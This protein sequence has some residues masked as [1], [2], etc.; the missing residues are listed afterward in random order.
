MLKKSFHWDSHIAHDDELLKLVDAHS[1]QILAVLAGHLHLTAARQRN[2]VYHVVV[3]GTA[4]YPCDFA[5]Y[6]VFE[7]HIGVRMYSLPEQLLTPDTDNHGKACF[8]HTIDYTDDA[9]PTHESYLKGNPS[10]RA[11][12]IRLKQKN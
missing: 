9:H 3:S 2:G 8:L 6:E 1:D 10:E 11:F 12:D 5:A 7:D 4:S